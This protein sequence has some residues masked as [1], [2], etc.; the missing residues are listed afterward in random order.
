[1]SER[2]IKGAVLGSPIKHSLSPLLHSTAYK[3]L[4]IEGQYSAIEVNSGGLSNFLE[5][6]ARDMD[7]LSLTMPLKEEA[8]D[9]DLDFDSEGL[10]VRSINTLVKRNNRW[11]AS[12]TD[13]SGFAK[14]LHSSGFTKFEKVLILGAGGTAR[15]IAGVIDGFTS[16]VDI[17]GRSKSRADS[18]ASCVK[19]AQFDYL[20]WDDS[21][22]IAPYDL[23][24]N[25]TPAGAADL[26]ADSIAEVSGKLFFDVIYKPWPTVLGQRWS[27]LGGKVLNGLELLIYQGIDQLELVTT[28]P[29]SDALASH[30]RTV[31][32]SRK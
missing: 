15:A 12:T 10:R 2:V 8:L 22:S 13:G 18:I 1:M 14:S 9:L 24:V 25:T 4:G 19:D 30:L 29:D 11:S 26:F 3:F 17:M 28:I 23:V 5:N 20:S 7:Y 6:F 27:D 21:L 31:L 16:H 32:A